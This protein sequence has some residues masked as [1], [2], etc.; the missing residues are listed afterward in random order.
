MAQHPM[1]KELTPAVVRMISSNLNKVRGCEKLIGYEFRNPWLL[2]E[3][4]QAYG[5]AITYCEIP[6]YAEG[7]TRFAIKGKEKILK[8]FSSVNWD[9]AYEKKQYVNL[10]QFITKAKGTENVLYVPPGPMR[11]AVE[12]IVGAVYLDTKKDIDT[13]KTVVKN[14]GIEL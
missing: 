3:A 9:K 14:L 7:N 13:V 5:P 11:D 8:Y 10:G 2:W 4:L 12:A 1:P 6:R